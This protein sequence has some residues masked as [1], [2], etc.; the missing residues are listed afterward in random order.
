ME[1]APNLRTLLV[2]FALVSLAIYV[3][4]TALALEVYLLVPLAALLL[5]GGVVPAGRLL[6]R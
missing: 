1:P 4:F 6:K 2:P 3:F 5:A